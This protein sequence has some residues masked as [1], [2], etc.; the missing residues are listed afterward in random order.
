MVALTK[1]LAEAHPNGPL[2]RN[3]DGA[4]WCCSSVKCRFQRLHAALGLKKLKELGLLP[5]KI[6]RLKKAEREDPARKEEHNRRRKGRL[7][8]VRSLAKKH[9]TRY[10]LYSFRH[11]ACTR[12][13]TEAKLDAVTTSVLMGHR[14]TT[15]ISRHYAHLT[16]RPEHLREAANRASGKSNS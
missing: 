8:A 10:S 1:R 16:A 9:G 15:T 14:D 4:A 7:A 12:M 11:S 5:P 13:L 3:S 2:F 6:K